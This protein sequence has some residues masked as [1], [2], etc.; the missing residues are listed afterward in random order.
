MFRISSLLKPLFGLI[1][2]LGC[3]I[4]LW[5]QLNIKVG[6]G[7]GY[8]EPDKINEIIGRFNDDKP[9]LEQPL[10]DINFL[11]GLE[12][13]L[14]YRIGISAFELGWNN[15]S[16]EAEAFGTDNGSP[17]Q[18]AL[19]VSLRSYTIGVENFIGDFGF[20]ASIGR[21]RL[22]IITDITGFDRDR[23]I[24]TST[25]LASRFHVFYQVKSNSV[26]LT[27]KPYIEFPWDS[28]NVSALN[29]EYFPDTTI[30]DTD[31]DTE[32]TVFGI[33]ILFYNGPQK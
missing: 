12:L 22:K 3:S 8:M 30:P 5:S 32:L 10:N 29:R 26:S 11:S 2:F 27:L 25:G 23:T 7:G 31:F 6:Y 17:F 28:Y 24:M 33:S 4:T 20:G 21:R 1:L 9:F 14:R 15:G 19:T 16:A 13:G 18:E